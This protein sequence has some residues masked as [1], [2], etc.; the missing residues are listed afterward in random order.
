MGQIVGN[1]S[2]TTAPSEDQ[3]MRPLT[4]GVECRVHPPS[5]RSVEEAARDSAVSSPGPLQGKAL[6]R[7][8]VS[9]RV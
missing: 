2:E 1:D 8:C 4:W 7:G 3:L 9:T 5:S 6:K